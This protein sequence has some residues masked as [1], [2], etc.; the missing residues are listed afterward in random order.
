MDYL[1]DHI[2]GILKNHPDGLREYELYRLL[3]AE[4]IVPWY[5]EQDYPLQDPLTLFRL[6]FLLFHLL[7]RLRDRLLDRGQGDLTIHCLRIALLPAGVTDNAPVLH[8]PLRSYYLD[9]DQLYQT[10]VDEVTTMLDDFWRR[11]RL[12]DQQQQALQSLGLTAPVDREAIRRRYYRLA[13]QHHP[14][15]GG[16]VEQFRRISA[17]AE[18][19]LQ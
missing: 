9:L 12:Q 5:N 13:R 15:C 6:H 10:G 2:H 4:R 7:Y 17:A 11:Y 19:L 14:D 18:L 3:R 8:D 16:D 1:L